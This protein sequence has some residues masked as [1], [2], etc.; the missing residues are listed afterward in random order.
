MFL[1]GLVA[2][3]APGRHSVTNSFNSADERGAFSRRGGRPL[4]TEAEPGEGLSGHCS[5]HPCQIAR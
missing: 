5:V 1:H 4:A 2:D 3:W